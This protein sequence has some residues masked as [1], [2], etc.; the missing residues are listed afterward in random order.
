ME[1][2]IRLLELYEK[3]YEK[4]KSA[5]TVN[6]DEYMEIIDESRSRI[7]EISKCQNNIEVLRGRLGIHS[8]I[9]ID[10]MLEVYSAGKVGQVNLKIEEIVCTIRD[11]EKRY[12][13]ILKTENQKV[14]DVINSLDI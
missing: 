13:D 11:Y 9:L 6:A 7:I 3:L 12:M 2:Y 5:D 10:N 4:F 8:D 14:Q 1:E